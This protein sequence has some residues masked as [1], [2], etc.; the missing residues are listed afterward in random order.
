MGDG[1]ADVRLEVVFLSQE[2][3]ISYA[4]FEFLDVGI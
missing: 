3:M 4:S 2:A 1:W